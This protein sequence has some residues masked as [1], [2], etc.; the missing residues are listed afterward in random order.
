[1]AIAVAERFAN[2]L[3]TQEEFEKIQATMAPHLEL[4]DGAPG[5]TAA[6]TTHKVAGL[7]AKIAAASAAAAIAHHEGLKA[8]LSIRGSGDEFMDYCNC[9]A[10]YDSA[11]SEARTSAERAQKD[12]FIQLLTTLVSAAPIHPNVAPSASE[13]VRV[14]IAIPPIESQARQPSISPLTTP[15]QSS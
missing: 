4:A 14:S 9:N 10:A 2:G 6:A 8:K 12:K 11:R 7:G 15:E 1:L 13:T 3:A 5:K